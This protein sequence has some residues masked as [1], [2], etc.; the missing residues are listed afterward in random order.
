MGRGVAELK[1]AEN[2]EELFQ[3]FIDWKLDSI[4]RNCVD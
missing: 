3:L 1:I 2:Y 4:R